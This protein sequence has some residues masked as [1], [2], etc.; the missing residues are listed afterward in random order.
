MSNEVPEA[1]APNSILHIMEDPTGWF[2][3]IEPTSTPWSQSSDP[4][5]LRVIAPLDGTMVLS[6]SRSAGFTL[7]YTPEGNWIPC[8]VRQIVPTLYVSTPTGF[9]V[10]SPGYRLPGETDLRELQQRIEAAMR[11][12]AMLTI[13]VKTETGRGIVVLNG[14]QLPFAVLAR[15]EP[16]R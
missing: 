15:A 4:V 7:A 1:S 11:E 5:A 16:D 8:R 2:V 13:D 3:H 12:G 9:Q 14:A 6:P 10:A